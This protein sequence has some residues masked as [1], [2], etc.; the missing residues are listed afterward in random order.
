M[1]EVFFFTLPVKMKNV[2]KMSGKPDSKK[3]FLWL[4][5]F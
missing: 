4:S 5:E 3:C 1:L 2:K